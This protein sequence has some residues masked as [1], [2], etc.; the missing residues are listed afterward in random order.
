M[1]VL[2]FVGFGELA[3]GLAD[4]LSRSGR[5]E[6]RAF[7]RSAPEPESIRAGR[8]VKNGVTRYEELAAAVGGASA[9]L[10]GVP[11]TA[12]LE[13]AERC[14]PLLGAGTLYVDLASA[15]PADKRRASELVS[16]TGGSYVDAGVLGT[17]LTSGY[18]VPIL[19]S[20][21]GAAEFAALVAPDGLKV[22]A[23]DG[24]AGDAAL[25]KLIRGVYLKGRDA[26]VAEMMLTA[27]R[28]GVEKLV[29]AS[30]SGPG[31]QVPFP[32]LA[33][34]V[35][36]SLAVHAGRRAEEL[37]ATSE[38]V[39]EAGVD[40]ALTRAGAQTL[41]T[42]AEL[43]LGELFDGERPRDAEAVLAAIDRRSA[44]SQAES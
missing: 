29:A 12:Q 39:Q 40:P 30:I 37:T 32:S 21:P 14:A 25:V 41:R 5:H 28:Y 2:T 43:G 38:L 20:G 34:R 19:A 11:A 36:C 4:G 18:E 31:E 23:I 16:G 42:I 26:L 44:A 27:R 17:V 6:L 15:S 13:V 8:L 1:A 3:A 33:E 22:D 9:V 35:L 24:P 7:L 10:A